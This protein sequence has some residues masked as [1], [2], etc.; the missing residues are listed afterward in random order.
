MSADHDFLNMTRR[1]FMELSGALL[2]AATVPIMAESQSS[3]F[4][5][6]VVMIDDLRDDINPLFLNDIL[7]EFFR[8]NIPVT[9]VVDFA[10]DC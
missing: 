8:R 5:T 1:R 7:T 3:G 9:C 10:A 4:S 6:V 2:P